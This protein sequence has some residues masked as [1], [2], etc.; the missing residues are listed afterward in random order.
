MKLGASPYFARIDFTTDSERTPVY[1]GI[2][3]FADETQRVCPSPSDGD[4]S[5]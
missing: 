2:Y 4:V 3:S 5:G 1:I